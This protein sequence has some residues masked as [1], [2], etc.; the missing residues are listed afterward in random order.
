MKAKFVIQ[1]YK[2]LKKQY[3]KSNSF[4]D[5]DRGNEI[6]EVILKNGWVIERNEAT[7]ETQID[8]P[9]TM[10]QYVWVEGYEDV[11]KI[12]EICFEVDGNMTVYYI[13][14]N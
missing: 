4:F 12:E 3:T 2:Y 9:L 13:D 14:H 6:E 1:N 5:T 7:K 10:E 11:F 8:Y